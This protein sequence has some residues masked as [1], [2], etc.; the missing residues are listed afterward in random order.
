[1]KLHDSMILKMESQAVWDKNKYVYPLKI[2]VVW[3]LLRVCFKKSLGDS[4]IDCYRDDSG[5]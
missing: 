3:E 4:F 5:V 2:K 1:M